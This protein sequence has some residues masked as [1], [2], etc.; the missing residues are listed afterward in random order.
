MAAAKSQDPWSSSRLLYRAIRPADIAIFN[1][2]SD[3]SIGFQNSNAGNISLP[4]PKDTEAFMKSCVEKQLLGAVI[5]LPHSS[6]PTPEAL[7]SMKENST[8]GEGLFEDWGIAIGEIHLSRLPPEMAHHRY[9]EIGI[10]IVP[11]YQ[12]KGY[13]GEAIRWAL[14]YA[15]RRAGLH[16]VRIRAFEWNEGAIKLY[17]KLGFVYE[18]K[19]RKALWHEG[20]WWD[21]FEMSMLDEE[22]WGMERKRKYEV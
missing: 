14:D 13:G 3:D 16:R 20:R 12:G 19:E 22:W 2:I 5:W 6:P 21:G 18:G 4:G 8:H 17:E 11:E 1:A 9:T 7:K 10:D 15:F